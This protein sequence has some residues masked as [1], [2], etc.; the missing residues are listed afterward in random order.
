MP[1]RITRP[2]AHTASKS[3]ERLHDQNPGT[4]SPRVPPEPAVLPIDFDSHDSDNDSDASGYS[5]ND[6]ICSEPPIARSLARSCRY[7]DETSR[8]PEIPPQESPPSPVLVDSISSTS[9]ESLPTSP[10]DGLLTDIRRQYI[11]NAMLI[12]RPLSQAQLLNRSRA[13]SDQLRSISASDDAAANSQAAA[14]STEGSC[15][16]KKNKKRE[17]RARLTIV[18]PPLAPPTDLDKS[19]STSL[20]ATVDV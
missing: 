4:L 7:V 13:L 6:D 5:A 20:Q 1:T 9:V 3:S 8:S 2:I 10:E 18:P 16:P 12:T 11:A 19:L 15:R 17:K 14:A